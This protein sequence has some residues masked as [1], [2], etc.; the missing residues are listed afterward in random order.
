MGAALTFW[1]QTGDDEGGQE[2]AVKGFETA[3]EQLMADEME[4]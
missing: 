1:Y 2:Q 4:E 3:G